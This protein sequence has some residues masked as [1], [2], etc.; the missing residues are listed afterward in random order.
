M[1][2]NFLLLDLCTAQAQAQARLAGLQAHVL[3]GTATPTQCAI[4]R[5]LTADVAALDARIA[6]EQA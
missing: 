3:A 5:Q 2:T 6:K 1:P 4:C